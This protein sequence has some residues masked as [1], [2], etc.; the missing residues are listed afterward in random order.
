MCQ[1][2]DA[3]WLNV[4]TNKTHICASYKKPTPDLKTP[5]D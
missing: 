2:K 4:Y 3:D 1:P 5:I